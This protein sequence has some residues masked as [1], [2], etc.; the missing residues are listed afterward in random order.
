MLLGQGNSRQE[1]CVLSVK[2]SR[3]PKNKSGLGALVIALSSLWIDAPC[4]IPLPRPKTGSWPSSH[5]QLHR[6]ET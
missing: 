6:M 3:G 5:L 4:A 2:E 1:H